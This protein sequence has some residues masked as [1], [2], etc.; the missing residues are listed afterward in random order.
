MVI[1]HRRL[2][3]VTVLKIEKKFVYIFILILA[4]KLPVISGCNIDIYDFAFSSFDR[5][6]LAGDNLMLLVDDR[7]NLFISNVSLNQVQEYLNILICLLV[8]YV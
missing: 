5:T 7:V 4:K 3:L 6:L 2:D 8:F 1:Y